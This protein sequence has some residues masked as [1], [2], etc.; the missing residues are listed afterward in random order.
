MIFITLEEKSTVENVKNIPS[1]SASDFPNFCLRQMRHTDKNE[2]IREKT[3]KETCG[4]D[5]P[6]RNTK[7]IRI[8]EDKGPKYT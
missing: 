3:P 2:A 1:Q 8:R 6:N 4:K 7:G 5:F